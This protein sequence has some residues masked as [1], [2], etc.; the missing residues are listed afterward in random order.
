MN[1]NLRTQVSYRNDD[2]DFKI[3][4]Y[5]QKKRDKS[6]Y[7]KDLI[8]ADMLKEENKKDHPSEER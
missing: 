5:L 1:T 4:G 2:R 8:E 6:S 3:Y 7:I